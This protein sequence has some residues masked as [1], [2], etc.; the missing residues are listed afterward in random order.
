MFSAGSKGLIRWN[1]EGIE[2]K[3]GADSAINRQVTQY[4]RIGSQN[5][6]NLGNA[7]YTLPPLSSSFSGSS[8]TFRLVAN[9]FDADE[10]VARQSPS[11]D[12]EANALYKRIYYSS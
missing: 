12:V 1:R 11:I 5:L 8:Q 7:A 2:V 6:S 3:I 4:T 9:E 10:S